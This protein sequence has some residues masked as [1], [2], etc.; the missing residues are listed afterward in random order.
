MS[1]TEVSKAARPRVIAIANQKGGVGKTTTAVNLGSAL[2]EAGYRVLV[3]DL[4]PQGNASTGLGESGAEVHRRGRLAHA[5]LLVGDRQHPRQ[6]ER[7]GILVGALED[8]AGGRIGGFERRRF[9][10][11]DLA[12]AVRSLDLDCGSRVR[13]VGGRSHA[14][15]LELVVRAAPAERREGAPPSLSQVVVSACHSG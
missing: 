5:P 12:A 6:L 13:L 8:L 14:I 4:D 2:A 1:G 3:I 10:L 7:P 15:P 9:E 11:G